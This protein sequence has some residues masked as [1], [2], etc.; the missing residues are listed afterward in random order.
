MTG[1]TAQ[2]PGD[3]FDGTGDF[4]AEAVANAPTAAGSDAGAKTW[5]GGPVGRAAQ[6]PPDGR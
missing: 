6:R 2:P 1:N 5:S 4:G 3:K